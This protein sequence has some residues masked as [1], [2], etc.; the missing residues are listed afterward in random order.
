MRAALI[1]LLVFSAPAGANELPRA[2]RDIVETGWLEGL[3]TPDFGRSRSLVAD[4]YAGSGYAPFWLD[5]DDEPSKDARDAIAVLREADARGLDARDYDATSLADQSA[6]LEHGPHSAVELAR[7]DVALTVASV[8]L[9]SDL[10]VGRVDPE[11]LGFHYDVEAKRADLPALVR[12]AVVEGNVRDTSARAEPQTAEYRLLEQQLLRYRALA[13]DA[14]ATPPKIA[15]PVRPGDRL[16]AAP[17]LA[18][19]LVALGDLDAH[20]RVSGRYEGALVDAVQR[21]QLRHGLLPDGIMGPG[22]VQALAVPAAARARQIVVALERLRWLPAVASER[23]IVVNVPAFEL[24]G[25]DELGAGRAPSIQMSVVVGRALENQTPFFMGEMATVVFAPYW[26]V[27]PNILKKEIAPKVRANPGY[28]ASQNMEIVRDGTV[29]AASDGAIAQ[30]VSG[31]ASVRQRPG[32]RNSLG[33]V[34]FLFPN[35]YDVYL[36]DTPMLRLFRKTRRDFSH[37]CIRLADARALA[38]WVLAGEGWEPERVDAMMRVSREKHIPLR[39][40]FPVVIAY[41]TALAR[42]DGTI[43]F[44]EDIYGHDAELERALGTAG[45]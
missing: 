35:P 16:R 29:L 21:F 9:V 43:S 27:P 5:R 14:R 4:L 8:R 34:K 32:G 37:G 2:I 3:R 39:N 13:A 31:N 45:R 18:R 10:H 12:D 20:T 23:A 11:P 24:W 44:Y 41:A 6:R 38:R 36:H 33:R 28:L 17:E 15:A 26:N 30:L 42:E 25:F 40:G 7:F 1:I 19:W 22:T